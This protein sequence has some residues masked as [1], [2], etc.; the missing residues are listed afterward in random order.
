M[1]R[2]LLLATA[3]VLIAFSGSASA[4]TTDNQNQLDNSQ[5]G[6]ITALLNTNKD[7][8]SAVL[9]ARA[10]AA[11]PALGSAGGAVAGDK[12]IVDEDHS[13]SVS[14][15]EDTQKSAEAGNLT[16][17]SDSQVANGLNVWTADRAGQAAG[18]LVPFDFNSDMTVDQANVAVQDQADGAV[19]GEHVRSTA[20]TTLH[21]TSHEELS[22]T[23]S[24][25][26][27]LDV[28]GQ[29]IHQGSGGACAG[30]FDL[31]IGSATVGFHPEL[32]TK[33]SAV[34]GL[35]SGEVTAKAPLDIS[36]PT[37]DLEID[38]AGCGAVSG[39]CNASGNDEKDSSSQSGIDSA[40]VYSIKNAAADYIAGDDAEITI[41]TDAVVELSDNAQG[42]AKAMNM[43]NAAASQ[44]ANGVNVAS[45][46]GLSFG[47]G[48][49]YNV[50]QTNIAYQ[51][52]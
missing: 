46:N 19:L 13:A 8:T 39:S 40:P 41:G 43:T 28:L 34:F 24:V 29:K 23:A 25:D 7:N 12:L 4:Q 14:L 16:N 33:G 17:S 9:P 44:V 45:A 11:L 52:Q 50:R 32:T 31:G 18:G 3:A 6:F 38:C 51:R 2:Q 48:V 5:L 15:S 42:E 27:E 35:I 26:T 30:K 37:V 47:A 49:D 1:K 20:A 21:T 10:N 22:T 36:T